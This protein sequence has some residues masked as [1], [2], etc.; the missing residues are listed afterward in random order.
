MIIITP[1][2]LIGVE[3][4]KGKIAKGKDSDIVIGKKTSK[5]QKSLLRK[6]C[7]IDRN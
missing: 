1:A 5:Y 7:M 6:I 4:K 3:D 2:Q